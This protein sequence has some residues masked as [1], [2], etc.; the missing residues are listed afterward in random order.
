MLSY[1]PLL[2][3]FVE[4]SQFVRESTLVLF[5]WVIS[6]IALCQIFLSPP[7]WE[8]PIIFS[9]FQLV[10]AL[11]YYKPQFKNQFDLN[12][13][14]PTL[15]PWNFVMVGSKL[16]FLCQFPYYLQQRPPFP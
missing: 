12:F 14:K 2:Y 16:I 5:F 11:S 13:T 4:E 6:P 8:E 3:L 7:F 15:P 10:N 1:I 9:Y